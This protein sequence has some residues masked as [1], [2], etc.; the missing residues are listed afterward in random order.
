MLRGAH[1]TFKTT[2]FSQFWLNH[3]WR[4]LR[5]LLENF[6]RPQWCSSHSCL[7]RS[8]KKFDNS[9]CCWMQI[10]SCKANLNFDLQKAKFEHVLNHHKNH[11]CLMSAEWWKWAVGWN[12][13]LEKRGVLCSHNTSLHSSIWTSVKLCRISRASFVHHAAQ[14]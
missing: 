2:Y 12:V 14:L 8:H 5:T 10:F 11:L 13:F 9:N 4:N 1:L 3:V 6:F 7:I